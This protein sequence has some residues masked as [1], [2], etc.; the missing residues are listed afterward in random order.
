MWRR[1]QIY[2]NRGGELPNNGNSPDRRVVYIV[3]AAQYRGIR[4]KKGEKLWRIG[5]GVCRLAPYEAAYGFRANTVM[6][7]RHR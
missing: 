1:E 2:K 6:S 3:T 5:N 7:T 4:R